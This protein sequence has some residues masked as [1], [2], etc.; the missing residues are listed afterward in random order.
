MAQLTLLDVA[1]S[2]G[3]DMAVGL[4]EESIP[5]APEIGVF[6]TRPIAGSSYKTLIRTGN[7]TVAF[8]TANQGIAASKSSWRNALVQCYILSGTVNLDKAVGADYEGGMSAYEADESMAVAKQAFI[9]VGSQIWY[10]VTTDANGFPGVKASTA[11]GGATT[12]NSGGS[13]STVQS[14]IYAVR[15]GVQ[16]VSLIAGNGTTIDLS[17]FA[18]QQLYDSLTLPYPGRVASL[19]AWLGLQIGNVNCVGRICN[20]G[21]IGETNDMADDAVIAELLATFP[22]GYMPSAFFM[23]RRSQRQLQISRT[24]VINSGPGSAKV[25]GS[26][27]A[28][29]PLPDSAFGIPIHVSDSILNTDAVESP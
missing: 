6:P 8:R 1:K 12:I 18:D 14:S 10:G 25:A 29:A 27:E 22:V 24:V 15:F 28:V 20:V 16:D 7:P 5:F 19:M 9:E 26:V 4:I 21:E 13:N 11:I 17:A 3:N 2:K 23:S